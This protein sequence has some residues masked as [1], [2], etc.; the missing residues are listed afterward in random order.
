MNRFLPLVLAG[1]LATGLHQD[2]VAQTGSDVFNV[3]A[4]GAK[5]DDASDDSA[6]ISAALI[7]AAASGGTVYFPPGI[8]IISRSLS[9]GP[10]V[11]LLGSGRRRSS[12]KASADFRTNGDAIIR[13]SGASNDVEVR[14]L[15]F[16][17][18]GVAIQGVQMLGARGCLIERCWFD[19]GF[20]WACFMEGARNCRVDNI[21]SEGTTVA[22]N[23]EINTSSYCEITNSHLIGARH[24]NVE[25]WLNPGESVGNRVINNHLEAAGSCGIFATGD[26]NSVIS[27]NTIEKAATNGFRAAFAYYLETADASVGGML[28]GNSFVNN[29]GTNDHG[30]VLDIGS[31]GWTVKGNSVKGS[32]N[33]GIYVTGTAHTVEGNITRENPRHGMYVRTNGHIISNN[34]CIDN[35]ALGRGIGDGIRLDATQCILTGNRC[36]DTRST[37]LQYFG[38]G[39]IG[40]SGHV[41]TSNNAAGNSN[42]GIYD[43]STGST[44]AN[45]ITK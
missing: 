19:A 2:A 45:N 34:V 10:D 4:Y 26:Q 5:G 20:W 25:I 32:G 33:C 12:L 38:I 31:K 17:S 14:D 18:N 3:K 16:I 42:A 13:L 9:P 15:G 23:V 41:V 29:G 39:I 21:I 11:T 24:N 36:T 1:F 40:G 8:Y 43:T 7:D 6:P 35:S 28:V 37:K 44:K 30:I 22:H 27:G